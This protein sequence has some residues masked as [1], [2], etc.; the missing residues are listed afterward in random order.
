MT[1]DRDPSRSPLMQGLVW[2][3]L[4]GAVIVVGLLIWYLRAS[5]GIRG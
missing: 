4:I 2:A 1:R 5:G 3:L